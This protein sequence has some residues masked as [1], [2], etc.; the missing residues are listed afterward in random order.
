MHSKSRELFAEA[1][2]YIPG[3]VNSPVRAFRAVGGEPFFVNRAKGARVW[4]VDGNEY[5]DYV[6]TWGPAILGH[7]HPKIIEAVKAA[8]DFGTSFGIPNPLEVTMAKLITSAVPSVQKVRLCNSGTEACM[9]AIRLARGFTKRDK[10]IKFD[11]CYHGHADSLLVKAGSGALT[12]GHPDSAGVPAAFTQHTIVVPFNDTE[13]VK[14]AFAANR[15]Q[16]AGIIVEPVPGNA[17]LYL[18]KPGYLEFLSRITSENGALLIFDEVMTG[19]RLAPGGAQERFGITPD[20]TCLGKI[21]GGGLPVGAFG[22][23]AEIMD[24]LA[25]LG[26]VYQAGTLSGNP[27]AMAAG[28]A[29]LEELRCS[30]RERSISP[31]ARTSLRENLLGQIQLSDLTEEQRQIAWMVV[32]RIDGYGYLQLNVEDLAFATNIRPEKI[33]EV[34]KV[35]QTFHPP[36]VGARDLRECLVLQLERDGKQNTLEYRIVSEYMEALGKRRIPEIARGLDTPVDEVQEALARIANLEPRPGR[37]FLPD[38]NQ[39]MQTGAILARS[40]E[41][42]HDAY[43]CLEQLGAELEAGMKDA[44]KS[45]GV[46][47]QFN[48]CGSM[49]CAY[50]TDRPVHDLADAM[51]SDRERFKKYF[52]G[53]LDEGIYFAPSQFEAG[54]ISAAHNEADIEKTVGAAAKV[55]RTL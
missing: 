49:F 10:I 5:V 52:H 3:G 15:D 47:V 44:A 22:G 50:F 46:P 31:V 48:R 32:E 17:G 11:G 39:D 33:L 1:L 13:A 51:H 55:M 25:P 28:I 26:P 42:G 14:A 6:C 12:F 35:I 38:N 7:A 27:L 24:M 2:R 54:F 18:P 30:T 21:I 23:R 37:A 19:F 8:A 53:M 20:L 29:A 4:D 9:T 36:G 43:E 41:R 16:I 45:A 40:N 34:L